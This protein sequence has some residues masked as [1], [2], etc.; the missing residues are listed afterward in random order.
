MLD[1]CKLGPHNTSITHHHH[2]GLL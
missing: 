1:K 2:L